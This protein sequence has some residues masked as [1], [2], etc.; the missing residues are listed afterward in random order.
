EAVTW[1]PLSVKCAEF[2]FDRSQDL[3]CVPN[4]SVERI[5]RLLPSSSDEP[6]HHRSC[7]YR[8][9]RPGRRYHNIRRDLVVRVYVW[10]AERRLASFSNQL[11]DIR[12]D[13]EYQALWIIECD[14]YLIPICRRCPDKNWETNVFSSRLA[15]KS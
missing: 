15:Q 4:P 12:S 14:P 3:L 1:T 5:H 9:Q 8:N 13:D 11:D 6:N 10:G 2:S 7:G